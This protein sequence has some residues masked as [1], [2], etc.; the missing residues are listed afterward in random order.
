MLE[1]L[2]DS[3]TIQLV[4]ETVDAGLRVAAGEPADL[5]ALPSADDESMQGIEWQSGVED[6]QE[7][8]MDELWEMLG[9]QDKQQLPFLN[10]SEDPNREI[11]PWE[12]T[13]W[14]AY[15]TT[16]KARAFAP[17]WHQLVGMIRMLQRAMLGQPV[18][19]MDGV[20]VGKTLEITGL[21]CLYTWFQRAFAQKGE[22]PGSFGMSLHHSHIS[23]HS[24]I[25]CSQRPAPPYSGRQP[26]RHPAYR[27]RPPGLAS[28]V[29]GRA[30]SV[31]AV[32]VF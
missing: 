16:G 18:L 17:R 12:A 6:F 15:L 8:S 10:T 26:P 9:L 7:K 27:R 32:W 22:F 14:A 30:P 29:G 11:D 23:F 31:S 28:P 1:K 20:G 24:S 25:V 21:I 13:K 19:L 4:L 2:A 5:L 3:P